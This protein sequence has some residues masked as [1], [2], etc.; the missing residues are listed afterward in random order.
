MAKTISQRITLEGGDDIKK[1]LEALGKAGE[2]SFKQIQDA[3]QKTQIDPA[4]VNETKQAFDQLGSAGAQLGTQFKALAESVI[5]FGSQG[6]KSALDV[7]SGLQKTAAAAQQV[8]SA[9][10][11]ASQQIGASGETAGAKLISTATAFK[12][13]AAGIVAAIAAITSSLTKGAVETGSALA[14]QAEKLKLTTAQWIE[15]RKAAAGASISNADF[16]KSISKITGTAADAKGGIAKLGDATQTAV[17]GLDGSTTIITKFNDTTTDTK[18]KASEAAT[19]LAKLGVSM[20]TIATGDT[21]AVM[22]EAALAINNMKN[23]TDQAAAGVKAF[24]DNWKDTIKVLLTAKTATVEQQKTLAEAGKASRDISAQQADEAKAV[25]GGWDDLTKAIRATKDQIGA[26]FLGGALAQTEWLTKLVDGSR[27]LLRIWLGLSDQKRSTFAA[28]PEDSAAETAFKVMIAVGQQLAGIW[29]DVLVPAGAALLN[30]VEQIAGNFEGVTK[31]QVAAF[32]ITA[33]IAAAGL[34]VALKGIGLVL[35]PF[36]ALISLFAG[37]GPILIPIIALVVL[38]WDQLSAGATKAMELIPNSLFAMQQAFQLLLAGDFAGFWANFSAAA[39]TAFQT[40]KQA[41]LQ[42]EGVFGDLARA[43][44]GQGVVQTSWVKELVAAFTATAKELPGAISAIV[45]ALLLMRRIGV[46]LAPVMSRIFGAEVSGTGAILLTL[47]GSMT[48]GLQALASVAGIVA[49]AFTV[50]GVTFGILATIMGGL[51]ASLAVIAAASIAVIVGLRDS[52]PGALQAAGNAITAL[53]SAWV[54]TPVANAWQWIKDTFN[55]VVSSLGSALDQVMALITAWVITPAAGAWQWIVATFNSAVSSLGS[56]ID[57]ATALIT[58]WVTTPVANAWQWIKDTFN[59]VV[60]SL[61]GGG[62]GGKLA[63]DAGLGDIGSH[64]GGGLLGGRGSG[65]SDSNLAWV[66]RG[67]YITPARAV[68][69]PGVLAF[70]E[71]LRRSGGNLRD[72]LNGM[73]RFALGGMVRA[74]IAIPAA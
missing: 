14:D 58:S 30:I 38:F 53:I 73:G 64:A 6:T 23:P 47:I 32:F 27:E 2:A 22:R 72:A 55:A 41:I 19:E 61:F 5:G 44:S 46:A 21:L 15:L 28:A 17:K 13:A 68:A 60:S 20:K 74:P 12:L 70:L 62:G 40:I 52:I 26:I 11:Q 56:A 69:Q 8:G 16:E 59:S 37:F 71:A 66:S 63:A 36:T 18:G 7:A 34:S 29:N 45:I 10:G 67:E 49:A 65:T 54:T 25:K 39:I 9:I 3:A 24:G 43:I 4:R 31:S 50:L 1:Q 51:P 33:A 48:G 35:S 42:T 57:Q